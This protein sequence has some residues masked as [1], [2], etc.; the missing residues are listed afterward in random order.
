MLQSELHIIEEFIGRYIYGTEG[1]VTVGPEQLR[2]LFAQS[3]VNFRS[4]ILRH[5][6]G[7]QREQAL[8]RYLHFHQAGILKLANDVD[9]FL[10]ASGRDKRTGTSVIQEGLETL[11][12]HFEI[13]YPKH[14]D[15]DTFL[16]NYAIRHL[17]QIVTEDT[18]TFF[19]RAESPAVNELLT[20]IT[21]S[22]AQFM[23]HAGP[24]GISYRQRGAIVQ[25]IQT[26]R[27][28]MSQETE[29]IDRRIF[30]LLFRQNFNFPIFINWFKEH[31]GLMGSHHSAERSL[32]IESIYQLLNETGVNPATGI[33]PAFPSVM[34]ALISWV[35]EESGKDTR[36]A[37]TYPAVPLNCSVSQFALFLRLLHL[38]GSFP[39]TNI[40]ELFRFFSR[41]FTTKKQEHISIKSFRKAFYSSEQSTAAIVLD[42]LKRMTVQVETLYFPK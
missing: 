9:T 23:D 42:L 11:A 20:A 29:H 18:S 10:K 28:A 7:N 17:E 2:E 36:A 8:S 37:E 1:E 4:R 40:S 39:V 15:P 6:F 27:V 25:A 33:D 13:T 12:D 5:F 32:Q 30:L 24:A 22:L 34:E 26:V 38:A 41:H 19:H 16:S 14:F 3:S 31:S 35:A 21:M